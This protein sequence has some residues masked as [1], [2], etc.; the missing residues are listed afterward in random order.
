MVF[1]QISHTKFLLLLIIYLNKPREN[2]MPDGELREPVFVKSSF[3][4]SVQI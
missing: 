3:T 2:R 4:T 1:R